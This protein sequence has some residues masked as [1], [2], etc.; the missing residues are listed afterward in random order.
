MQN[1]TQT[2]GFLFRK[3][4]IVMPLFGGQ[5]DNAQRIVD[6]NLGVH[7]NAYYCS[8]EEL[9]ESFDRLLN[10]KEMAQKFDTSDK[11]VGQ[12]RVHAFDL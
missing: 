12:F 9:L 1:N 7:L 4:M 3:P 2:E 8:E 10:D 11:N 6:K 5:F